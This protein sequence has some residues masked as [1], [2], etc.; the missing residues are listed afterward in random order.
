MARVLALAGQ[1]WGFRIIWELRVGPLSF[2]ALRAVCGNISPSVLADRLHE[3]G[4]LEIV[5]NIPRLGYRLTAS[6]ERLFQV[7]AELNKWS[8]E[9]PKRSHRRNK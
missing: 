3:L 8:A 6:G 9:L 1:R 2:R 5:E 4:D 7:L